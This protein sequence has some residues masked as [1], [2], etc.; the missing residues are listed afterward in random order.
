MLSALSP[1]SAGVISGS[2][3]AAVQPVAAD[4]DRDAGPG[5]PPIPVIGILLATLI[6]GIIIASKDNDN[7]GRF[8]F[9]NSPA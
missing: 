4:T 2:A 9:P 7:G 6:L 8:R 5:F 1:V 3:A